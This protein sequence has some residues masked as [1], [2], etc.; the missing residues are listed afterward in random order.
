M[1]QFFKFAAYLSIIFLFVFCQPSS[2]VKKESKSTSIDS[3]L[4]FRQVDLDD[5]FLDTVFQGPDTQVVMTKT[6][7]PPVK[8]IPRAIRQVEGFRVQI[9]AGLDS[10]NALMT[11]GQ[12]E[13]V[14]TDT[15]YFFKE[16]GLFKLQT[17]DYLY[18]PQA[19][20]A[21]T[22]IRDNGYPGAWIVKRLINLYDQP[23]SQETVQESS[24]ASSEEY[25][26]KYKIQVAATS[27]QAGAEEIVDQLKQKLRY[28]VY[29]LLSGTLYKVYVGNF[30]EESTARN[31]LTEVRDA[32][33]P[34]AWLVY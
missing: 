28:P 15:V 33:Y 27:T 13:E 21:R 25:E 16:K 22:Y 12:A 19:D 6:V 29:Y 10:L 31:V 18:R 23:K 11:L 20:S 32:G 1:K 4:Y 9:F 26:G 17:G 30:K 34:D 8:A 3:T 24:V 7:V 5:P 14:L 2:L